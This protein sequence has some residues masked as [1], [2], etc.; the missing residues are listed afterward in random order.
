MQ[1]QRIKFDLE[2]MDLDRETTIKPSKLKISLL[3]GKKWKKKLPQSLSPAE[4]EYKGPFFFII[5]ADL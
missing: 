3:T 1:H 5:L 4:Q 2:S